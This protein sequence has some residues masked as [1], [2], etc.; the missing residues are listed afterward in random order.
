MNYYQG[1]DMKLELYHTIYI[2]LVYFIRATVQYRIVRL[3]NSKL[4]PECKHFISFT[5]DV[6][7]E[8]YT[9]KPAE[10]IPLLPQSVYK[11]FAGAIIYITR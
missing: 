8:I 10:T 1:L 3:L 5:S 9:N 2:K 11:N 7:I 6:N 4:K